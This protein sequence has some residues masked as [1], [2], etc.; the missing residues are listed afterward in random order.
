MSIIDFR[1]RPNTD[2][3]MKDI[4]GP[5]NADIWKRPLFGPEPPIE[6]LADFVKELRKND[7]E[8]AVFTGRQVG[9]PDKLSVGFPNDYVAKCVSEY[10]DLLIGFAGVDPTIGYSAVVEAERA[11]KELNLRGISLDPH[12]VRL[13]PDDRRMYPI[14][15]KAAELKVPVVFT[16]GPV[17]GRW[18]NPWA[19]DV[20]AEDFPQVTFIC[21]HACWPEV[22]D[23]ISLP[24]RR[25]NVY[26]EAS[27]YYFLPGAEPFIEAAR[28]IIQDRVVYASAFPFMPINVIERF[29]KLGFSDAVFRKLTY[30]NAAR[31]LGH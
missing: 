24:Y 6:P 18:G 15:E 22:T 5:A 16:M 28:T 11:V 29:R 26:L 2:V 12:N 1:A 7:V 8:R 21:S 9:T 13:M 20:V 14:Y 3:Y 19:V 31:I 10:P 25:D 23:L 4:A 27:I 17:V 30:T